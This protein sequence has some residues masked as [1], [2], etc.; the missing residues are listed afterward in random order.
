MFAIALVYDI[1][2]QIIVFVNSDV[3]DF[4]IKVNFT[5]FTPAKFYFPY[6]AL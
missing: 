1:E 6:N 5:T 4:C 2:L 3:S